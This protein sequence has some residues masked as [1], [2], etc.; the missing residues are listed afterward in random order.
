M[1]L[2]FH[3]LA[4][5]ATSLPVLKLRGGAR[6][7]GALVAAKPVAKPVEAKGTGIDVGLLL[8]FAGW[9]LGNYYYTL[10]NKYAL[11]AAGGAT[12][13]PITIG[14]LQMCIGSLYALFLWL[15]PDARPL[16]TVTFN[17]LAKIVPVATCSA[18]AHLSSII[19]MNLGAVSFSQIVKAAEPAFAA[20][21]GVTMY[22][23]APS[24]SAPAQV[25]CG[26]CCEG[27]PLIAHAL[28]NAMAVLP[29]V[30]AGTA[31]ASPRPSGC[32]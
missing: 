29:C 8:C 5:P 22:A 21:L 24:P 3:R 27:C 4:I 7:A 14:F 9:Y 10:N 13:F 20:L 26:S 18:G 17:D 12:G 25:K 2:P 19:S 23:K 16:P 15:A 32:A 11:N 6:P 28:T 1:S 31:R 30:R